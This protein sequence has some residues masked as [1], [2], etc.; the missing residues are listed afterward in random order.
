MRYL[1][2]VVFVILLLLPGSIMAADTRPDPE[3][4][5]LRGPYLQVAGSATITIRWRT[6][7]AERGVVRYGTLPDSLLQVSE[8]RSISMEHIVQLTGLQPAT[9]Y[10]YSIG[11]ITHTLRGDSSYYF[12][13]MP[14]PGSKGKYRIAALGDCGNNSVNQRQVR[15]EVIKYLK[16]SELTAWLLLGDNAYESG[17][18]A[19]YQHNFFAVYQQ[20][21]LKNYPLFPAPG[22]HDYRDIGPYRKTAGQGQEYA[23]Y[24]S[25]S[26][27]QQGELG[28]VP[29]GNPAYYSF[30]IGNI[31]F[32]SLDSY[33]KDSAMLR[34]YDTLSAQVQWVKKDLE[35]YAGKGWIVAFWHHPPYTMSSHNSDKENELI[36]IRE[37]FIRI[38]ERYGVDLV[39]CGHSHGYERTRLING[40]YGMEASFDAAAH[41]LSGSSGRYDGTVSSCP[42]IK[43]SNNEPG[44]VYVVSGSAGKIDSR[45]QTDF[46]HNAMHYSNVTEGGGLMLEVE[47][48]RLDLRWI[49]ADGEVRDQF[50]MIK[51]V[52]EKTIAYVKKGKPVTLT[53]AFPSEVYYWNGKKGERQFSIKAVNKRTL[54]QV[55]DE[56]GC[57]KQEFEILISK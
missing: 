23:Y 1:L 50:T 57:I 2:Q 39:L 42:Y 43:K 20:Q 15:D 22:N 33:G 19:E 29:S 16:G 14:L 37:N 34:M 17:T 21:L 35:Q 44:T 48:N 12:T 32:L 8:S 24:K 55:R 9:R 13:T 11:G 51:A 38:L 4:V 40:Y 6:D 56:A 5:L 54:F 41:Q 31:H 28:G 36:K 25:F 45:V 49:C 47:D 3:P 27:P 46:P 52:P 30:D 7:V 53:A 26:M 10:Y 18:D